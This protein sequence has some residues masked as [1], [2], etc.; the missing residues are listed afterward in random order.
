MIQHGYSQIAH[1]FG[2]LFKPRGQLGYLSRLFGYLSRVFQGSG[3]QG[4]RRLQQE[5][6]PL[7]NGH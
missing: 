2:N 3:M 6:E 7:I 5:F 1:C 4:F